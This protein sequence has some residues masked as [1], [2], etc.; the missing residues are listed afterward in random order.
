MSKLK[1]YKV[2]DII[3]SLQHMKDTYGNLFV[4]I[5]TNRKQ[6]VSEQIFLRYE[7]FQDKHDEISISDF[8]Y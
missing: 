4:N 8:P 3:K 5:S 1:R 7:Q 2:E 6:D